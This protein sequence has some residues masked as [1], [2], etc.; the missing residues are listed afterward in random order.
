MPR[1]DGPREPIT[2]TILKPWQF[3]AYELRLDL[4]RVDLSR[5]ASSGAR[6]TDKGIQISTLSREVERDPASVE[7]VYALHSDCHRHQPPVALRQ[8][9]IPFHLW[10]WASLEAK[11]EALP[12][13]YFIAVD[14]GRYVGL[15]TVAR[16]RR[17]PGVL[18]CRFTGVLPE[19]RGRGI[20]MALKVEVV[21]F[22]IENGY[23]ELRATVLAEN[24]AMLRIN[25]ALGFQRYRSFVLGYPQLMTPEPRRV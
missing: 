6:S 9:P 11:D 20:G 12:G 10:S 19:N 16:V 14:R 13:A 15:S 18:E 25:E 3:P 4:S 17:L 24:A 2:D 8:S 1:V 23:R 5:L 21:R 22:G 7:R